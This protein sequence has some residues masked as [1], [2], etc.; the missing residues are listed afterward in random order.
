MYPFL[1]ALPCLAAAA[2]SDAVLAKLIHDAKFS[3]CLT[4]NCTKPSMKYELIQK[5][6]PGYQWC[7]HTLYIGE[8]TPCN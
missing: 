8:R 4:E 5:S 2:T 7:V 1:S 6:Q 3:P